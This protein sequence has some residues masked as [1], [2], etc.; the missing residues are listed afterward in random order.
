MTSTNLQ[1][2]TNSGRR[3]LLPSDVLDSLKI[4]WMTKRNRRND[5][6]MPAVLAV[7]LRTLSGVSPEILIKA[8]ESLQKTAEWFPSDAEIRRE[9]YYFE[10]DRSV[11]TQVQ[12]PHQPTEEERMRVGGAFQKVLAGLRG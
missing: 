9:A 12:Q 5:S 4:L 3:S 10:P 11:Q 2:M 6:E 7:Y 1:T 8:I